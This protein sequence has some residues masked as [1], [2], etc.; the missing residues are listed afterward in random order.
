MITKRIAIFIAATMIG[1]A[2]GSSTFAGIEMI[3][4]FSDSETGTGNLFRFPFG[5]N[6]STDAGGGTSTITSLAPAISGT[7]PAQALVFTGAGNLSAPA[8]YADGVAMYRLIEFSM[9]SDFNVEYVNDFTVHS[10]PTSFSGWTF[11]GQESG[12]PQTGV[13]YT[14]LLSGTIS[15]DFGPGPDFIAS[16]ATPLSVAFDFGANGS[17]SG[18][19]FDAPL[20]VDFSFALKLTPTS[21][22]DSDNDGINDNL[23]PVCLTAVPEPRPWILLGPIVLG[24]CGIRRFRCVGSS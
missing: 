17:N 6:S 21:F 4:H 7:G 10:A 12:G 11:V 5:T 20:D 23:C 16:A 1:L 3:L 22:I 19:P 18:G 24:A 8:G 14:S 13:D 9:T 15:Q 2:T